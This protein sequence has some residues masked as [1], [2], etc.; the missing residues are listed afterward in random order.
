MIKVIFSYVGLDKIAFSVRPALI[1]IVAA[2]IILIAVLTSAFE[3][4]KVRKLIP[5]EMITE[6]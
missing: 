4:R 3:G 2:G 1:L 6:E 5:M